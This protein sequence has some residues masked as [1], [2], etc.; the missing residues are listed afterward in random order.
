METGRNSYPPF[1]I[2]YEINHKAGVDLSA[3]LL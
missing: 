2:K 3:V 1:V